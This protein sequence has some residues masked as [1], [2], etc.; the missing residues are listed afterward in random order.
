MQHD[1]TFKLS[2]TEYAMDECFIVLNGL[3]SELEKFDGIIL[4]SLFMLP[5]DV[6]LRRGI[7]DRILETNSILYS[8]VE[9][10]RISTRADIAR[11]EQVWRIVSLL[12]DCPETVIKGV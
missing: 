3:L 1:L 2:A 10:Y 8:A 4:Y 5:R 6:E 12:D 9:D 11:V 7:Y